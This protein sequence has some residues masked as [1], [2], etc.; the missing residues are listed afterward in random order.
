MKE[1]IV[2]LLANAAILSI[3]STVNDGRFFGFEEIKDD[4]GAFMWSAILDEKTCS[5]CEELDG[6]YFN[7]KDLTLTK[8]EPPL[9]MACRCILVAVLKEELKDYPVKF[10]SFDTSQISF[11]TAN[12]I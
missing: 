1:W 9:H 5:K 8:I 12:K 11:F 2:G 3:S 4:I 6:K 7:S 10:A